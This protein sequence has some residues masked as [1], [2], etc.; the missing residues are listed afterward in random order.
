ML[1]FAYVAD[2]DVHLKGWHSYDAAVHCAA[3]SAAT[4]LR[5][6][7]PNTA[8]RHQ[9]QPMHTLS[10]QLHKHETAPVPSAW[11]ASPPVQHSHSTMST[12]V[13]AQHG[14][15]PTGIT[16]ES[17]MMPMQHTGKYRHAAGRTSLLPAL[18]SRLHAGAKRPRHN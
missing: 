12:A 7:K 10:M 6:C 11:P 18:L 9:A 17:L 2:Q 5:Q 3:V 4:R 8:G 16:R 13:S 1:T 15:Q 14:V